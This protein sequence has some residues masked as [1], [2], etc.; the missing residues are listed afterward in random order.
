MYIHCTVVY[1]LRFETTN[2][3]Y[4]LQ[5]P[6]SHTFIRSVHNKVEICEEFIL[7]S[8]GVVASSVKD[9]GVWACLVC[10][11]RVHVFTTFTVDL[12]VSGLILE[13]L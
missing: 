12:A 9:K 2:E 1:K 5:P 6:V 10:E 3:F 11:K 8:R 7:Q 13:H 4:N